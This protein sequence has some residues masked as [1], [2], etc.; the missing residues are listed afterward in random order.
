VKLLA[1]SADSCR[2]ESFTH[3][4]L[5]H[6]LSETFAIAHHNTYVS[7]N[8]LKGETLVGDLL[9]PHFIDLIPL[10]ALARVTLVGEILNTLKSFMG[11]PGNIW[12]KMIAEWYTTKHNLWD[13]VGFEEDLKERGFDLEKDKAFIDEHY[14]YAKDGK[15]VHERVHAYVLNAL[16]IIYKS[17]DALIAD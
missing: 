10:N 11:I 2:H 12:P 15:I 9:K 3:L 5:A 17:D 6:L 8:N 7:P 16:N 13:S 4:G 14:R 1:L